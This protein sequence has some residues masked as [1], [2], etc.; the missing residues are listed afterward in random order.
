MES[1]EQ[2][3]LTNKTETDSYVENR[4]MSVRGEGIE[5]LGENGEKIKQKNQKQIKTHGHRKQ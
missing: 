4:L 5:A 2:N 1:N 3:K